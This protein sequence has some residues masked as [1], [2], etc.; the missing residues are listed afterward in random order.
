M[1]CRRGRCVR[2]QARS[3][4]PT[5]ERATVSRCAGGY[6]SRFCGSR[7]TEIEVEVLLDWDSHDDEM[8]TPCR[9]SFKGTRDGSQSPPNWLIAES[10]KAYAF[11]V[12]RPGDTGLSAEDVQ[13]QVEIKGKGGAAESWAERASSGHGETAERDSLF[14]STSGRVQRSVSRLLTIFCERL[15]SNSACSSSHSSRSTSSSTSSSW[16]RMCHP[17][18]GS[19]EADQE[20]EPQQSADTF[21]HH[22]RTGAPCFG[23]AMASVQQMKYDCSGCDCS[24]CK[25]AASGLP[26]KFGRRF[27]LPLDADAERAFAAHSNGIL[28][29]LVPRSRTLPSW[30]NPSGSHSRNGPTSHPHGRAGLSGSHDTGPEKR[31]ML[32]V[33]PVPRSP[34]HWPSFPEDV[35]WEAMRD[36]VSSSSAHSFPSPFP[37][38]P[39]PAWG[40]AERGTSNARES[41]QD[42]LSQAEDDAMDVCV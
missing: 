39:F 33:N 5:D 8:G 36:F 37:A 38:R 30:T 16:D 41:G 27:S 3:P 32:R 12:H 10:S 35:V 21:M 1:A 13:V 9:L 19:W 2:W 11:T 26:W 25:R 7:F 18:S 42:I 20:G 23:D 17:G 24:A 28:T 14:A 29:V 34:A 40:S 6:G 4:Y 15:G 31:W 22:S